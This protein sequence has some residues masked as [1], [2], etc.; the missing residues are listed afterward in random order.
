MEANQPHPD[1]HTID[2][3]RGR[4][5]AGGLHYFITCCLQRPG[6]GLTTPAC[7]ASIRSAWQ[8][9]TAAGDV[10]LDCSTIMP[11][12]LHARLVLGPRLQL[13]RVVAKLKFLTRAALLANGVAWQRDFFEHHLR[14]DEQP[15]PFAR[16]IFLNPYRVGL[17]ERR[18]TWPHTY[19]NPNYD[20]DFL[21]MLEDDLFPPAEWLAASEDA[22]GVNLAALGRD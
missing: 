22:L 1:R 19:L 7:A 8:T 12:H 17:L 9:L 6:A 18:A 20:F 15:S 10:M 11:D 2:L 14:P 13:G 21:G 16:Y 5:S 3:H 4:W